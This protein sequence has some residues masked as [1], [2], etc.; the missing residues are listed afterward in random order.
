MLKVLSRFSWPMMLGQ[1]RLNLLDYAFLLPLGASLLGVLLAR[2][3]V[4]GQLYPYGIS[5]LA[6]IC[7]G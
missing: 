5:Y 4:M 3:V 7:F 1:L 2:A 6:G